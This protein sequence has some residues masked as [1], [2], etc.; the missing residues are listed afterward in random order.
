MTTE[1]SLEWCSHKPRGA[2]HQQ[3]LGKAL[4]PLPSRPRDPGLPA[5]ALSK[6]LLFPATCYVVS[7][8]R[9]LRKLIQSPPL[10]HSAGHPQYLLLQ[11][12]HGGALKASVE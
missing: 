8:H 7:C 1:E 11:M 10:A 5:L 9:R 6:R 3:E 4:T 2:G 12:V